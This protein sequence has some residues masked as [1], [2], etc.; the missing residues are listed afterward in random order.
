MWD[1]CQWRMVV[2]Q[3][4]GHAQLLGSITTGTVPC[5][6]R[7]QRAPQQQLLLGRS[8]EGV[9]VKQPFDRDAD[10]RLHTV[11]VWRISKG[12]TWGMGSADASSPLAPLVEAAKPTQHRAG[13][14]AATPSSGASCCL[15]SWPLL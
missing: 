5:R 3:S 12:S 2:R 11:K 6:L 8:L 9:D 7:F 4:R 15:E 14:A 13:A 1:A 10:R